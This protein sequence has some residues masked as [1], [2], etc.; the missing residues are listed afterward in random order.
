MGSP[1]LLF[2]A[3]KNG[4]KATTKQTAKKPP[5]KPKATKK[6]A[7]ADKDD[8]AVSDAE[9][10]SG[11]GANASSGIRAIPEGPKKTASEKY[12]KVRGP[13]LR[14]LHS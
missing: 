9:M 6:A 3:Q 14:S 8:N 1:L 7:L 2:K 10:S 5:A 4:A 11:S 13:L 12:T